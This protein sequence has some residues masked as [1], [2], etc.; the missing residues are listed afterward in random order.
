MLETHAI[1]ALGAT[2]AAKE[3]PRSMQAAGM[4]LQK[5]KLLLE[6]PPLSG[7]YIARQGFAGLNAE[8]ALE[9]THDSKHEQLPSDR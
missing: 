2:V 5:F 9:G 3:L 4:Q 6:Q 7:T 8:I 1:C